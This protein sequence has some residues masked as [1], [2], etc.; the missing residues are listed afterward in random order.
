M[1]ITFYLYLNFKDLTWYFLL[2]LHLIVG[3]NYL[4]FETKIVI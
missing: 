2:E 4:K 1:K 3:N